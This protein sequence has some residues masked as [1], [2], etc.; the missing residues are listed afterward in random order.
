VKAGRISATAIANGTSRWSTSE[1]PQ[2]TG[3]DE[4]RLVSLREG[5][6]KHPMLEVVAS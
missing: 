6:E 4:T 3:L 5:N 1:W 2:P